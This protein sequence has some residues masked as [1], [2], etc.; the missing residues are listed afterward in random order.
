MQT[1]LHKYIAVFRSAYLAQ[2]YNDR[3]LCRYLQVS[4]DDAVEDYTQAL[5][6]DPSLAVARYNRA[7]IYY[8]LFASCLR[9]SHER[10]GKC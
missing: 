5:K 3:G 1:D 2:L 10:E 6:L 9:G 7:T 4:F 8:R